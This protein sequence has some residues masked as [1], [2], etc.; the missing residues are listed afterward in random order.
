LLDRFAEYENAVER[1]DADLRLPEP[2]R[3]AE[4]AKLREALHADADQLEIDTIAE[5]YKLLAD[6]ESSVLFELKQSFLPNDM[7]AVLMVIDRT[8]DEGALIDMAEEALARNYGPRVRATL[9]L[10]IDK[11]HQLA[12]NNETA[13][14][15]ATRLATT[16]AEWCSAHPS[17]AQRLRDIAD[18]RER[19]IGEVA[20]AYSTARQRLGMKVL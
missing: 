11:L 9:P 19:V 14:G 13:K 8:Q 16:F 10:V 18:H 2:F 12:G 7:A 4:R 6:E 20:G 17:P 1:L 15:R 3:V 5:R